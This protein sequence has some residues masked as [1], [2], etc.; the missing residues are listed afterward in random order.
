[1]IYDPGPGRH[2]HSVALQ[3]RLSSDGTSAYIA[4]E[5][6][7]LASWDEKGQSVDFHSHSENYMLSDL[8]RDE[9]MHIVQQILDHGG[10]GQPL[11]TLELPDQ[12]W[13][14]RGTPRNSLLDV[15]WEKIIAGK[16]RQK[17]VP[18]EPSLTDDSDI[19]SATYEMPM[20]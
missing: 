10:E 14:G 11:K 3:A 13:F 19:G 8:T 16:R 20:E 7:S 15:D 6:T 9:V 12:T 4:V 18:E 2:I 5:V 17:E 1:M